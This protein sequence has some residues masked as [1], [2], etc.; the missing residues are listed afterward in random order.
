[1]L[2][3]LGDAIFRVQQNPPVPPVVAA[4]VI[5]LMIGLSIWVLER[6]VRGIEVVA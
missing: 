2:D 5:V 3:V 1:M 6:K 4:L